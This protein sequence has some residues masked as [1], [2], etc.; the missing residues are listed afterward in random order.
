MGDLTSCDAVQ[1]QCW[2]GP[3]K[4]L[5]DQVIIFRER[6]RFK[7]G[8]T[9]LRTNIKNTTCLSTKLPLVWEQSSRNHTHCLHTVTF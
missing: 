8:G 6:N 3:D 5:V 4:A 7:L 2:A 9:G 1:M